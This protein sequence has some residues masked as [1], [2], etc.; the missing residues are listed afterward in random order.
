M[1]EAWKEEKCVLIG[2]KLIKTDLEMTRDDG[3]S[4]KTLK[5]LLL[6]LKTCQIMERKH[7]CKEERDGRYKKIQLKLQE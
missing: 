5:Q 7:K 3:R 2:E 1:D 4:R 6:I